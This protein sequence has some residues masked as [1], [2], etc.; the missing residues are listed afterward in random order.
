MQA[1]GSFTRLCG[2]VPFASP[3][4]MDLRSFMAGML[5]SL[6][7]ELSHPEDPLSC[8]AA[9]QLVSQLAQQSGPAAITFLGQNLLSNLQKL[10]VHGEGFL[11]SSA[12]QVNSCDTFI[13]HWSQL[14]HAIGSYNPRPIRHHFLT[15][16]LLLDDLEFL[17]HNPLSGCHFAI[18]WH[19]LMKWSGVR[20]SLGCCSGHRQHKRRPECKLVCICDR[21]SGEGLVT[22]FWTRGELL[23]L[24][25][26]LISIL[27]HCNLLLFWKVSKEIP[28][29]TGEI[30]LH[31]DS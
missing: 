12:L 13:Q 3:Q 2:E 28:P 30:L 22:S 5:E 9:L 31:I 11:R 10:F 6:T 23:R 4:C 17:W 16:Q 20:S 25:S 14:G 21:V 1:Q 18:D 26:L 15:L 27:Q 7:E 29:L 8:A 24:G 19:P